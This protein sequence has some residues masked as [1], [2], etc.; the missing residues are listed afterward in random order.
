MKRAIL[1]LVVLL[2]AVS[3]F[4]L[5][6]A[7]LDSNSE[8]VFLNHAFSDLEGSELPGPAQKFIKTGDLNVYI[9][10]TDGNELQMS[11]IIQDGVIE[12]VEDS[13]SE[14]PVLDVHV[15]QTFLV[16]LHGSENALAYLK[17]ALDDGSFSYKAHG[18]FNKIKFKLLF[19]F[20]NVGANE[21][22][23][24][25]E[26]LEPS[27]DAVVIEDIEEVEEEPVEDEQAGGLLTGSVVA[28][29]PVVEESSYQ[30]HTVEFIDEGFDPIDMTIK[31]GDTVIWQNVREGP[32]KKAFLVG[33][34]EF[35][36]IRSPIMMP[37]DMYKWEFSE[38]EPGMYVFVDGI[39]TTKIF[40][41]RI[42][43]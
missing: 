22:E 38:L 5:S 30:T 23:E 25:S 12:R 43:E 18:L 1:V 33:S 10:T 13:L 41:L 3:A 37:G 31:Q 17:R 8:L 11:I 35:R 7:E 29:V 16:G 32:I 6:Y 42:E 39:M 20:M 21:V 26:V 2:A 27:E 34:R 36:H 40:T 4:G 19:M 14:K 24:E 28:D 15:T 9:T